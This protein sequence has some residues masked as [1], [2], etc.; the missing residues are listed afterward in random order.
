MGRARTFETD[1]VAAAGLAVVRRDGWAAVSVRSVA[2][3]LGV[4]PMALYREVADA[5]DL[6]RLIA[7]AAGRTGPVV[8]AGG[9]LLEALGTWGRALYRHLG[10]FPGLAGEL[11]VQWTELPSWLGVIDELLGRAAD[12]GLDDDA[13]VG[14]VNAV[15]AF[16][17]VRAQLG[18]FARAAPQRPLAPLRADRRRRRYPNIRRLRPHFATRRS[19]DAFAFGLEALLAG[20]AAPRR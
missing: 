8:P 10:Q 14:T 18:D 13:V 16:V 6:R 12:A 7:D 3:E 4:S 9:D 17:L 19:D 20:L 15:F 2:A 11:L 1:D 5:D